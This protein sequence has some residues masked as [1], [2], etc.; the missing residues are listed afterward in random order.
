MGEE[1]SRPSCDS[2][3]STASTWQER[4]HQGLRSDD[5]RLRLRTYSILA[6]KCSESKEMQKQVGQFFGGRGNEVAPRGATSSLLTIVFDDLQSTD[7]TL[8]IA[9]ARVLCLMTYE[10]LTNQQLIIRSQVDGDDEQV[11]VTAGWVHVF[12][13]PQ[14]LRDRYEAQCEER[15]VFT[16]PRGLIEFVSNL[17]KDNYA[18]IYSRI[19]RY[20]AEG[21]REFLPLCWFH[22]LVNDSSETIDAIDVPDPIENVLGF[23]L[24]PRQMQFPEQDDYFLHDMLASIRTKAE[25]SRLQQVHAAFQQVAFRATEANATALKSVLEGIYNS[26]GDEEEAT[27]VNQQSNN[28]LHWLDAFPKRMIT[29]N[30]LL[31]WCCTDMNA[32][33]MLKRFGAESYRT[34]NATFRK[35][36]FGGEV[37]QHNDQ[38]NSYVWES[39]LVG[40]LLDHPDLPDAFKANIRVLSSGYVNRLEL[41]CRKIKSNATNKA[42]ECPWE[43]LFPLKLTEIHPISWSMFLSKWRQ[44]ADAKPDEEPQIYHRSER[45]HHSVGEGANQGLLAARKNALATLTHNPRIFHS[46]RDLNQLRQQLPLIANRP[47]EVGEES[48]EFPASP[49]RSRSIQEHQLSDAEKRELQEN[50]KLFRKLQQSSIELEE[51]TRQRIEDK[52]EARYKAHEKAAE[53]R[54]KNEHLAAQRQQE[55]ARSKRDRLVKV[56]ERIRRKEYRW[57]VHLEARQE[58]HQRAQWRKQIHHEDLVTRQEEFMQQQKDETARRLEQDKHTMSQ[59]LRRSEVSPPQPPSTSPERQ[60]VCPR[61]PLSARTATDPQSIRERGNVYG[62]AASNA[63]AA[64]R[65]QTARANFYSGTQSPRG[66]QKSA[67]FRRVRPASDAAPVPKSNRSDP[68]V[69]IIGNACQTLV[70]ANA[71]H[72]VAQEIEIPS[73]ASP[74]PEEEA[75][76]PAVIMAQYLAL[77]KEQRFKLHERYCVNQV[78]HKLTFA[79]LQQLTHELRQDAAWREFVK[80]AGGAASVKRNKNKREAKVTYT[81]FAGVANHLGISM[82]PKRIQAVAR[83]LDPWKTGF[84]SWEAFY[85]WWSSQ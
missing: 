19:G 23:Y 16:T 17:I 22:A 26:F 52:R 49:S 60:K 50:R 42:L 51:A 32:D 71:A 40:A 54:K 59:N 72:A 12:S 67:S 74:A 68:Q 73:V 38:A 30:E 1:S 45:R 31:S 84:V 41:P 44:S 69:L 24:V 33:E 3:E 18:S 85:T 53:N 82:P 25:L 7:R 43:Y 14:L 78:S 47:L 4:V 63:F 70:M 2:D 13:V 75:V 28:I 64:R 15:G 55:L 10:N 81:A 66:R 21:C 57:K 37:Q 27:I 80:A 77:D 8:R 48:V 65:P 62:C 20:Y 5:V 76:P 79:V 35:L 83:S 61:R 11:G 34:V 36:T 58:R 9:A 56:Q 6:T 46:F 39:T 29:W